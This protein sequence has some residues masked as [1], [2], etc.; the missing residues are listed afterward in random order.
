M[1]NG[2]TPLHLAAFKGNLQTVAFL[3]KKGAKLL[4]QDSPVS[5]VSY[6]VELSYRAWM[7]CVL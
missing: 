3:L 1:Q 4:P 6:N 5:G 7:T 2:W